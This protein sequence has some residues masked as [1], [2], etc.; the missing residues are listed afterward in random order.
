[1]KVGVLSNSNS[2]YFRD[3]ARAAGEEHTVIQL[4]FNKLWAGLDGRGGE[5]FFAAE[6]SLADF[7]VIFVRTMPPG[8]L[9]Q[10][11]LRMD[12]LARLANSGTLVLNSPRSIEVSVDK[13]LTSAKLQQAGLL[14]PITFACQTAD[15]AMLA[16]ERL[17]GDCVLK[18]LFGSEGRGI[19]RL[20]DEALAL[21]AFKMLAQ[22][23]AILYIQQFIPH[24]GHDVRL[25]VLG[26]EV[27]GMRRHSADDWRTNISRGAKGEAFVPDSSLQDLA[28]RA[29]ASVGAEIAGVDFLPGSDGNLYAIE[30][31][32]VPG[33]QALSRTLNVDVAARVLEYAANKRSGNKATG[34]LPC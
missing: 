11:I 4:D 23:G 27:L 12:L 8:S 14:S 6:T 20:T 2:W 22:L 29:A 7:D 26:E 33:W 25:F 16:F 30:V 1:M 15:E 17:G 31:N 21:R 34:A 10:V 9:E 28:R 3:L 5:Q 13:Y 19:T 24:A 32:A 18:P